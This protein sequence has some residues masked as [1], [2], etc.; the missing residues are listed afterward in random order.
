[1]AATGSP[2][3]RDRGRMRQ[4][5]N[6]QPMLVYVGPPQTSRGSKGTN[7]MIC[8]TRLEDP[9]PTLHRA[10]DEYSQSG[11]TK[12]VTFLLVA[13]PRHDCAVSSGRVP[14]FLNHHYGVNFP[15]RNITITAYAMRGC[16][17]ATVIIEVVDHKV[18][19]VMVLPRYTHVENVSFVL[20]RRQMTQPL[21][22]VHLML[23]SRYKVHI[24]LRNCDFS[25]D[26]SAGVLKF[27]Q[28][29][30]S[31]DSAV[32]IKILLDGITVSGL[33]T[34]QKINVLRQRPDIIH[35]SAPICDSFLFQL[36]NSTFRDIY[37]PAS[38]LKSNT[39]V[40]VI[41]ADRTPRRRTND[42]LDRGLRRNRV[43][44]IGTNFL[45]ITNTFSVLTLDVTSR[46]GPDEPVLINLTGNTFHGNTVHQS[47]LQIGMT[48]NPSSSGRKCA[49]YVHILRC[50]V[51][52]TLLR[53]TASLATIELPPNACLIMEG[54]TFGGRA[55]SPLQGTTLVLSRGQHFQIQNCT[56]S[57]KDLDAHIM[58]D[59]RNSRTRPNHPQI[60][61]VLDGVVC[62]S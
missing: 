32:D 28:T 39:V 25:I 58:T 7:A 1:M 29:D 21:D 4:S 27:T 55:S 15:Y 8:G 23:A 36:T 3:R 9:C 33:N 13:D 24:T 6:R 17:K 35:V 40:N 50:T 12:S 62:F 45:N 10:A 60:D 37:S 20:S 2:F 34:S 31:M 53:A 19:A 26:S 41:F 51:N 57:G 56:F 46:I 48:Y 44:V 14:T 52:D 42:F 61:I 38:V 49:G 5:S 54:C 47:S 43:D 59:F 30:D 11:M 18:I 16:K 22:P